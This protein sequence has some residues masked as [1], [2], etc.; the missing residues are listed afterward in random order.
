MKLGIS[1]RLYAAHGT[2][3]LQ[4]SG[5]DSDIKLNWSGTQPYGKKSQKKRKE[6]HRYCSWGNVPSQVSLGSC[7]LGIHPFSWMTIPY[8][9]FSLPAPVEFHFRSTSIHSGQLFQA[10]GEGIWEATEII[11]VPCSWRAVC[12]LEAT[13][14]CLCVP[15]HPW[16]FSCYNIW[17]FLHEAGLVL[18]CILGRCFNL[19]LDPLCKV[20]ISYHM[21]IEVGLSVVGHNGYLRTKAEKNSDSEVVLVITE[22]VT[23]C[24]WAQWGRQRG[25]STCT[26]N[27][28]FQADVCAL[29]TECRY[30]Q[31]DIH[32]YLYSRQ[33]LR[34]E[35]TT[36]AQHE[37]KTEV[38]KVAAQGK[39]LQGFWPTSHPKNHNENSEITE[40]D[41]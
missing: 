23:P 40:K 1:L 36:D 37:Q 10:I 39:H 41:I 27:V 3:P 29:P 24:Q 22:G 2:P 7:L 38:F 31:I 25:A 34:L 30:I 6:Y 16:S 14:I 19:D 11:H 33:H 12:W 8:I 28:G 4:A 5:H 9:M 17:W 35:G 21:A 26:T 18:I 13:S 15:E 32:L 20:N